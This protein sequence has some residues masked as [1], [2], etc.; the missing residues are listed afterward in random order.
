MTVIE[1]FQEIQS[2]PVF[3]LL[4]KCE[5]RRYDPE[6]LRYENIG[7]EVSS[8]FF[9]FFHRR[10]VSSGSESAISACTLMSFGPDV[11][12]WTACVGNVCVGDAA[13]GAV[14]FC[15]DGTASVPSWMLD[16]LV[17]KYNV[18]GRKQTRIIQQK[19]LS[20]RITRRV[21]AD[22][23]WTLQGEIDEPIREELDVF[24]PSDLE[25]WDEMG[26]Y[27]R[28]GSSTRSRLLEADNILLKYVC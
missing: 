9:H 22:L 12:C 18:H 4:R 10:P 21:T 2:I 1:R 15:E 8:S 20:Y 11:E 24:D 23:V 17:A 19:Q 27:W 16:I 14:E 26:D 13:V 3:D 28:R 6:C 25:S 7:I 5:E